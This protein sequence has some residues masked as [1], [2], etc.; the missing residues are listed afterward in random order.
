MVDDRSSTDEQAISRL[1]ERFCWEL[2]R[3]TAEGFAALFTDDALYT[4]GTR[5]SRGRSEILAFAAGRRS[6]QPRTSRHF[7]SGLQ[8]TVQSEARA[9]GLSCCMA[10]SAAAEP[11]VPS[12]LPAL[13]ADFFDVYRKVDGAWLFAERR[14]TPIF[15]AAPSTNDGG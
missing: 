12:T 5:V 3:G 6:G 11:P 1:N 13:V 15:T 9:T 7:V 4:N 2:D 8:I 10:F 14:I